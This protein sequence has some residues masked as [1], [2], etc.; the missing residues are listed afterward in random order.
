MRHDRKTRQCSTAGNRGVLAITKQEA[1]ALKRR[2][3]PALFARR[4]EREENRE[5]KFGGLV[6]WCPMKYAGPAANLAFKAAGLWKKAHRE[7]LDIRVR[8]ETFAIPGLDPALAGFTILHLSDLH[9]DISADLVPA[10]RAALGRAAGRYDIACATG[11]FNNFTVHD[12]LVALDLFAGLRDAFTAPLFGCLGNHDSLRD[13]PSLERAGCRILLNESVRVRR[14]GAAP[15]DPSLL[16][17]GVDDPN[18]FATHDLRAALAARRGAEPAVLLAHAPSIHLEAAER[19]VSL[20][21]C[22]HVHGGQIC[23]P[24]GATLAWRHW[25]FPRH[26]WKGRWR[27]GA[28]QGYTTSGVGACGAPLRLNCPPELVLVHLEPA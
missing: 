7:F 18:R 1:K 27:E 23:L 20:V 22:G 28:T 4:L 24:G 17:A 26:V 9:L 11:D 10:L 8:E 6:R 16:L 12:D 2:I 14:R 15:G 25:R 3:G 5:K 13:V 19:G 21:L